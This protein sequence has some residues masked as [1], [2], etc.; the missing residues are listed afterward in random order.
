MPTSSPLPLDDFPGEG[1]RFREPSTLAPRPMT[2]SRRDF[3][4]QSGALVLPL[5]L[6]SP[7][8]LL[9]RT[10]AR[11]EFQLLRG[12][13][14]IF[15]ERGGTIGWW[16]GP[17]GIL[18]VD[19][20]FA[21][22]A[23]L[24]VE[25]LKERDPRPVDVL[26]NTHHHGDHTG[27]NAVLREVSRTIVAHERALENLRAFQASRG[28]ENP[29]S[30]PDQTFSSEWEVSMG[31]ETIRAKHYGPAHTGGDAAIHFQQANIVHL[32]DLLNN[33]GYPN[34]DAP[35]GGSIQGW[36]QVL[37][38]IAAEHSADTLYIFGHNEAGAPPTGTREALYAQ[39]DY[40]TAV[41]EVAAQALREGKSRE[42][43]IQIE[44]LPGF[45]SYGGTI[46][47]LPLA[48]GVA[49]DELSARD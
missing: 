10:S 43:A 40:F 25:G 9:G 35:S 16:I 37:E 31:G 47:R 21:D 32:G 2:L 20:Q 3:L 45:E 19:S 1:E 8:S 39:R 41:V 42:E 7:S 4:T 27:G 28:G 22:T 5:A 26:L 17:D 49:Y 15:S 30:L 33:R 13:V 48:V 34:I 29:A 46:A 12:G 38:T 44:V 6:L 36:M 23:P 18:V 24:L 14:G 11:A